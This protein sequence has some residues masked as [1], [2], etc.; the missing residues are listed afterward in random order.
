[1]LDAPVAAIALPAF[2][3]TFAD[4]CLAQRTSVSFDE[5][6]FA[7]VSVFIALACGHDFEWARIQQ[8]YQAI[9]RAAAEIGFVSAMRIVRFGLVDV[10]DADFLAPIPDGVAIDDAIH[11]RPPT[12]KRHSDIRHGGLAVGIPGRGAVDFNSRLRGIFIGPLGVCRYALAN[13]YSLVDSRV[14]QL[15]GKFMRARTDELYRDECRRDQDQRR[16]RLPWKV[17]PSRPQRARFAP[18]LGP[19]TKGNDISQRIAPHT[20]ADGIVQRALQKR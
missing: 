5:A 2:G 15:I 13:I 8:L 6:Q 3:E 4:K 17:A 20:T 12:A 16:K 18:R 11:A 10:G 9:G 1:M 7:A 14:S 19:A